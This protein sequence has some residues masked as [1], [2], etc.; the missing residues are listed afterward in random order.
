MLVWHYLSIK[1][2]Y[3]F[4]LKRTNQAHFLLQSEFTG[5]YNICTNKLSANKGTVK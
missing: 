3:D 5:H 4:F 1:A 2:L